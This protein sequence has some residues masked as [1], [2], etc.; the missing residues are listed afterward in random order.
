LNASLRSITAIFVLAD[1]PVVDHDRRARKRWGKRTLEFRVVRLADLLQ[2][3]KIFFLV[4]TI[5]QS[6]TGFII[7]A[8]SN[9]P[10]VARLA[11][12]GRYHSE[13]PRDYINGTH[14][15]CAVKVFTAKIYGE[16]DFA[17]FDTPGGDSFL[18]TIFW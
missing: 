16:F 13:I 14:T 9:S 3:Y 11:E 6:V 7:A 2:I 12:R 1:I 4:S 5:N 15:N 8:L 17:T 10:T 18:L